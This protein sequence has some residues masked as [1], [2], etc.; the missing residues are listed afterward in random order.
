MISTSWQKFKSWMRNTHVIH[1]YEIVEV[2]EQKTHSNFL[3]RF[4]IERKRC[5]KCKKERWDSYETRV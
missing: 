2:F 4:Y 5:K 1:N 3:T